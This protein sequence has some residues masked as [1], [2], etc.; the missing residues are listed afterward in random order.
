MPVSSTDSLS[1]LVG[2]SLAAHYDRVRRRV[3]ALVAPLST[4]QL[5]RRPYPY[6]NSVGHLLLHLTGNLRYYIGTQIAGSG[7]VRDRPGEF[8]DTSGRH[9]DEVL[10]DFDGAVDMVL[11]TLAAQREADWRVPYSGVG[12]EDVTDRLSMFLRCAAH[13]DHHAGQMIYLCKQLAL[14]GSSAGE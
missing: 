5:W 3:H 12:A 14:E 8:G 1:P 2:Q 9:R 13:A 10:R 6:G 7:Y 11:A 4:E